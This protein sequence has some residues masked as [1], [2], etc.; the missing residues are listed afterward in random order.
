M[1]VVSVHPYCYPSDPDPVLSE[2][3]KNV[4]AT[5]KLNAGGK[6]KPVWI[7]E[8][9]WPTST[10]VCNEHDEAVGLAKT[11]VISRA[12]LTDHTLIYDLQDDGNDPADRECNFGMIRCWQGND[13]PNT[14]KLAYVAFDAVT[15]KLGGA[16]F[17]AASDPDQA[18]RVYRFRSVSGR[19]ILAVWSYSGKKTFA[20]KTTG[21]TVRLTD[22]LG[23]VSTLTAHGGKVVLTVGPDP[24]YLDGSFPSVAALDPGAGGLPVIGIAAC[25]AAALAV[26]AAAA[27]VILR[28]CRRGRSAK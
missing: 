27:A 2:D 21:K 3:L 15:A 7:T 14:A 5:M 4:R 13:A 11:L 8:I 24:V 20:L 23:N 28:L 17:V 10:G 19:D 12:G 16:K 22:L 9:G 26:L 18:E 6:E 1:D 25:V